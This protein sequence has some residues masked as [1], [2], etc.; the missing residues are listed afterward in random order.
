MKVT[1]GIYHFNRCRKCMTLLTKLQIV[2]S[3]TTGIPPCACGSGMFGP[4][5]PIG[6]EW[7]TPRVLR[8]VVYQ[9]LG[10]LAPAPDDG[11]VPPI[12]ANGVF[13]SVAPLSVDEI[14]APED[15]E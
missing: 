11:I 8:M 15:G 10:L 13:P 14:R 4:T 7:V 12:P 5:N 3:F 6:L 1:D 2:K 9:L